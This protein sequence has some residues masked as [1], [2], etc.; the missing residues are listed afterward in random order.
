MPSRP[1]LEEA[2][3]HLAIE[4]ETETAF[5]TS[6]RG[7]GAIPQ[8]AADRRY[9]VPGDVILG[10]AVALSHAFDA[11]RMAAVA[12]GE[13]QVEALTV[14]LTYLHQRLDVIHEALTAVVTAHPEEAAHGSHR[15]C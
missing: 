4:Y 10:V 14:S 9:S 15:P 12:A 2:T 11:L 8:R 7:F 3:S 13:G 6:A 5:D 1:D